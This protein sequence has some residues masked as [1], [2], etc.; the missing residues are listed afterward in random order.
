MQALASPPVMSPCLQKPSASSGQLLL[1]KSSSD[2]PDASSVM[3]SQAGARAPG[4]YLSTAA[5]SHNG[6]DPNLSVADVDCSFDLLERWLREEN[7]LLLSGLVQSALLIAAEA[8]VLEDSDMAA[9]AVYTLSQI[10][11]VSMDRNSSL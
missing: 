8:A 4:A 7:D 2:I 6:R 1:S 10:L 9:D 11:R 5:V 3:M